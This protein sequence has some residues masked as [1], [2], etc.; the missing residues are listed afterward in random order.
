MAIQFYFFLFRQFSLKGMLLLFAFTFSIPQAFAVPPGPILYIFPTPMQQVSGR[1]PFSTHNQSLRGPGAGTTEISVPLF[2]QSWNSGQQSTGGITTGYSITKEITGETVAD[3]IDDNV[4]DLDGIKFGATA[5]GNTSGSVSFGVRLSDIGYGQVN[6]DY[7]V[8]VVLDFPQANTFRGGDTIVIRSR[9]AVDS[10]GTRMTT[11]PLGGA[12]NIDGGITLNSGVT[13]Q[14]CVSDCGGLDEGVA[15]NEMRNGANP[16]IRVPSDPLGYRIDPMTSFLT[17]IT[18]TVLFPDAQTDSTH[19]AADGSMSASDSEQFTR[20]LNIDI[21]SYLKYVGGPP[22]GAQ[23]PTVQGVQV[24]YDFIDFSFDVDMSQHRSVKFK[25]ESVQANLNLGTAMAWVVLDGTDETHVLASGNGSSVPFTAG[26]SI[27]LTL[28]TGQ[29]TET[30]ADSDYSLPNNFTHAGDMI[31]EGAYKNQALKLNFS[32]P[33]F[34]IYA[35]SST[36]LTYGWRPFVPIWH[37]TETTNTCIGVYTEATGCVGFYADVC[38]DGYW[39]NPEWVCVWKPTI[40]QVVAGPWDVSLG[41]L[42][43]A[44]IPLPSTTDNFLPEKTH[45]LAFAGQSGPSFNLDPENPVIVMTKEISKVVNHGAGLRTV[46]YTMLVRNDGDVPLDAVQ[47]EDFLSLTFTG[48]QSFSV[49]QVHSCTLTTNLIYDG[50]ADAK[51]AMPV[52]TLDPG[53]EAVV[54]LQVS[55]SPQPFPP[56]YANVAYTSGVSVPRGTTV[57][58][59]SD[60]TLATVNMG[61]A[62]ISELAD[63]V[64]FAD[65]EVELDGMANSIGHIGANDEIKIEEHNNSVLAGD[66]WAREE[67]EVEGLLTA[68]YAVSGDEV[69]QEDDG[70]LTLTGGQVLDDAMPVYLLP[71]AIFTAGGP[72]VKVKVED[73]PVTLAPGAYGKVQVKQGG[74]LLLT[75]GEYFFE[76]LHLDAESEGHDGKHKDGKKEREHDD[77]DDDEANEI[78]LPPA[79]LGFD[80]SAG[81]VALNIS[82]KVKLGKG[83]QL[84]IVSSS[85]S[86]RDVAINIQQGKKLRISQG[87]SVQGVLTAPNAELEFGPQSSIEGAAYAKSIKMRQGSV[88]RYHAVQWQGSLYRRI[89]ANCDGILDYQ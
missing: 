33:E 77:D 15:I 72:K 1:I 80:L 82:G 40:P 70:V 52:Y 53:E 50:A 46:N 88:A 45:E 43:T 38:T 14:I 35:G 62:E 6:V 29:T 67:I 39:E 18:G 8:N 17:G 57:T 76:K 24:G 68:D 42:A 34:E 22:L 11:S 54:D 85:G 41:H 74:V 51:L 86:T 5:G 23:T 49:D 10:S 26:N 73:G 25:P 2:S 4:K 12:L 71:Q 37:C 30:A 89:D 21:D 44:S 55:V 28:P 78:P 56:L 81:A 75:A 48:A 27:A 36:C 83:V 19:V 69:E 79:I 31:Y 13:A 60:A 58:A 47:V 32:V 20:E 9:Y 65:K 3:W 87:A 64:L 7:P 61:P 63:F 66:L 16:I 59:G 84:K